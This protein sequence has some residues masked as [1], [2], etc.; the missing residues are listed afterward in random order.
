MNTENR[1]R[2]ARVWIDANGQTITDGDLS[3]VAGR[4]FVFQDGSSLDVNVSD[5]KI[6]LAALAAYG[7]N[8]IVGDAFAGAKKYAETEGLTE[9]EAAYALASDKYEALKAGNLRAAT[10]DGVGSFGADADVLV[11]VFAAQ[12]NIRTREDVVAG[13]RTRFETLGEDKYDAWIKA[14]RRNPDFARERAKIVAAKAQKRAEK[15]A[16][17]TGGIIDL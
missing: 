1:A 12:G 9:A 4:R 16:G 3:T 8:H 13:L 6:P 7:L 17:A 10:S 14:T 5:V 2:I 11:A 15:L